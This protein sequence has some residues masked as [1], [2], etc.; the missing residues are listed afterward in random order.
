[1]EMGKQIVDMALDRGATLA[2]IASRRALQMSASHL[3]YPIIGEY[4]G[5]GTIH[6][7]DVRSRH[8]LFSWSKSIKSALV[9]GLAHPEKNPELDWWDGKG[10]PGNRRLIEMLNATQLEIERI[11]RVKTHRLPYFIEKGGIF[12]KDAA[13]LAGLGTIGMNNMVV[14]PTYGPRIR[15]RALFLDADIEPAE[16]QVFSPCSNCSRPCRSVCPEKA[17]DQ[18]VPV[19][20]SIPS[21]V[22]KPAG[23]GAYN[24][25]LCNVRME[26]DVA[27]GKHNSAGHPTLIKF[28]RLCEFACPVGK[29]RK[30]SGAK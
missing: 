11:L 2:G 3:I 9:I 12:L 18:L 13:V 20:E 22:S 1:M 26:K 5:A 8:P 15:F 16:P 6:G 23:D 27:A 14:T 25:E 30:P 4:A 19:Y 21:S 29:T 24:R 7:G 10:T 28:C 17:M